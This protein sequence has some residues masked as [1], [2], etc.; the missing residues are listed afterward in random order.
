VTPLCPKAVVH[1]LMLLRRRLGGS[2]QSRSCPL[3]FVRLLTKG[4]PLDDEHQC[5]GGCYYKAC[6]RGAK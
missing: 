4:H 6:N 3:Q 1:D 2:R 5:A